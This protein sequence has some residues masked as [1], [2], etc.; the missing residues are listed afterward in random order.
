MLELRNVRKSYTTGDFTQVAL[1]DVSIAFR[2]NEFVAVLGPSG[3]GKTTMLN[4]IGGLDQYDSGDLIIDGVST[5]Q[6]RD[7]DWDTYRNN[8]VGFVFQSYNLIPHQTV[9]ANVEL[10]LTLAGVS[11]AERRRRALVA[12]DEVGLGDHVHKRPNQL[13]GGQMQRV[14][15]ARALIND[16]EIL[17]ADEPTGAL[18]SA[19]SVQIMGLLTGIARDRLV[20]MV[21]HNPELA[22]EYATRIV[23]LS[24]GHIVEDTHPFHPAASD[25]EEEDRPRR[26]SMG[27]LTAIALSFNNLMTKKGRTLM[28]SFAGSI[29]IIGIAAI[30]ALANGVNGYIKSIEEDTLSQYPLTIQSQSFDVTAM[31]GNSGMGDSDTAAEAEAGTVRE[32]PL[33]NRMF[34]S[35]GTNDLA[36]LK[37]FL[38]DNGGGIDQMVNAVEYGYDLTP[39][40]YSSDTSAGPRQV[41]PDAA[42]A[43]LGFQPAGSSAMSAGMRTSAFDELVGD[44]SLVQEQ[45]DVVA[46]RWP[47]NYDET[48]VVLSSA[49]GISDMA[50]Y[51]MGLLDPA[52]LD[53]MIRQMMAEEEIEAPTETHDFTYDE[54]MGVTFKV[55]EATDYYVHD[56]QFDVWTDRSDDSSHVAGLVDDGIPL[57][58]VGIARPVESGTS[59]LGPGIYYTPE[60]TH[61]LMEAAAQQPI[62]REQLTDPA[63]NVFTGRGFTEEDEPEEFDLTSLFTID[64]AA[65]AEAFVVDE[66]QLQPDLSGLDL[67]LDMSS[68]TIDQS[69]MPPLDL[70]GL[71]DS[72]GPAAMMPDIPDLADLIPPADAPTVELPELD[73]ER[74]LATAPTFVEAYTAFA[75]ANQ[76]DPLDI[77]Y[78][79][80]VFVGSEEGEAIIVALAEQ[81]GID[82]AAV[83]EQMERYLLWA[84]ERGLDPEDVS[85]NVQLFL[86]EQQRQMAETAMAA[87]MESI[88]IEGMQQQLASELQAELGSYME[89]VMQVYMAD[90]G[91]QLTATLTSQLGTALEDSMA[92]MAENLRNAISIDQD[93]FMAG[94]RMNKT[95]EEL[96]QLLMSMATTRAATYEGNLRA[97]GYAAPEEPALI[98]IYPIDFESK[99]QVTQLLDDYNER[100]RG[101]GR[102]EQVIAYTD[103]V[104]S[105]MSSVTDIINTISYVLIAFVAISLVVSSIMIGVI[106]YISVLERKKEI[107]ILRAVGASKRDIRRVFNAETLIVG[108]VA[109]LLGVT[110]TALLTIPTNAI[111]EARFDVP[112]VA[113]LPWQAAAI[114]VL[115]SMALTSLAGLLPASS[116]SRKDPVEALR[117][118]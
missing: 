6:Y 99:A 61:H 23:Q 97:L 116:A 9:L 82:T 29:G 113:V 62:V 87:A 115:I 85:G 28:T 14:A 71:A 51:A 8:R 74:V 42:M 66:S 37:T 80:P 95:Q 69:R 22:E 103:L 105:L 55:I 108:F 63:T 11:R 5:G 83:E 53:E 106:T 27:F 10:A 2:D 70:S 57:K 93:A 86:A 48:V 17:L 60:L 75:V 72:F 67:D 36:T 109:G 100:M 81:L 92:G 56:E 65:V 18:D 89:R 46:G 26:T 102:E 77:A 76:I 31:L 104:G 111:V 19:T 15:I 44:L 90:V 50:L 33:M 107:G 58:V 68:I 38:D 41:N 94:F 20:V 112:N 52:Q 84:A 32:V 96:T 39:H 110:I 47:T 13:S 43:A 30:L 3:S 24:D 49:G 1:D 7:R 64:E 101:D 78:T 59:T 35:V 4:L 91:Q 73:V 16:P 114:L 12:L 34:S 79:L 118:E 117:S 21:T 98:N 45:Y 25:L 54:V 88:D 40:I